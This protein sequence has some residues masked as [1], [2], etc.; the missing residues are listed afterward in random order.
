MP[1]NTT[2]PSPAQ[3]AQDVLAAV[4]RSGSA[5]VTSQQLA[6][7]LG[8]K[9]KSHRYLLFD[10]IELLLDEGR[11][12]TGKKG[13]YT[14]VGGRDTMEGTIDII[15][16]GAGYVRIEGHTDD[17]YVHNRDIGT[18]LHGDRVLVKQ[19]GGRGTRVEGK[20]LQVV[21]RRRTEFVGTIHKQE[22]RMLLVADDQRVQ[23]PFMIPLHASMN[24]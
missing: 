1:K 18:A 11:I 22:G 7:Q 14:A 2:S 19:S 15:A 4:R 3:L 16:S 8:F 10:A 20:V 6:L 13:R 24:A 12:E 17:I 21:K 9:D 5:G 23:R